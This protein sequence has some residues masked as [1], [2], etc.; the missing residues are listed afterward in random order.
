MSKPSMLKRQ[1]VISRVSPVSQVKAVR[2]NKLRLDCGSE[3][4]L[5]ERLVW[6]VVEARRN[7]SSF[8]KEQRKE[9]FR[10]LE[11]NVTSDQA[12]TFNTTSQTSARSF[13]YPQAARVG[14]D[15]SSQFFTLEIVRKLPAAAKTP[16]QP[17][18]VNR[19]FDAGE[20]FRALVDVLASQRCAPPLSRTSYSALPMLT[21]AGL[22]GKQEQH[23]KLVLAARVK[24]GQLSLA[25]GAALLGVSVTT[26]SRLRRG[27]MSPQQLLT[28]SLISD[29]EF[30]RDYL[31][32][33][34]PLV[35]FARKYGLSSKAIRLIFDRALNKLI[36][37]L[38]ANVDTATE[39]G[40]LASHPATSVKLPALTGQDY[41]RRVQTGLNRKVS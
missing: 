39:C 12:F 11:E 8:I 4:A 21:A 36:E 23:P 34:M 19:Q 24:A 26:A 20:V 1:E 5:Q 27:S 29:S 10:W 17:V 25:Q 14:L 32:Q 38:I 31:S 33:P 30:F 2:G 9:L 37:N 6:P 35:K 41:Q 40:T 3:A 16:N 15:Q 7:L 13:P 22:A 18:T 28:R